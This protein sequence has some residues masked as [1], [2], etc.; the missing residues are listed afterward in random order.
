MGRKAARQHVTHLDEVRQH[1]EFQE[2]RFLKRDT[3][4][5]PWSP[6]AT[7]EEPRDRRYVRNV[8]PMSDNQKVLMEA[9]ASHSL[10]FALGPAGTGKTYL[11]IAQAVEALEKGS[12]SRIVL[13]RPAVEAE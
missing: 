5:G 3:T 6:L 11:A 13:T 12:V 1:R 10:T 7:V 2:T 8:R 9:I 4:A